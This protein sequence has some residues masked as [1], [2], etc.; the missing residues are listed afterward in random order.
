MKITV[1]KIAVEVVTFIGLYQ[2]VGLAQIPIFGL[3]FQES[4][5]R[6]GGILIAL[7][8]RVAGV[9]LEARDAKAPPPKK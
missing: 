5:P 7:G 6:W 1:R 4:F 9:L 8:A 3:T 2:A